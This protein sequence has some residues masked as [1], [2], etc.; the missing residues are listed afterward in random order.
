[1]SFSTIQV[2][3]RKVIQLSVRDESDRILSGKPEER[4]E[5]FDEAAG[6]VKFKRRKNDAMKKLDDRIRIWFVF[7]IFWANWNVRWFH[8]E[9]QCEKAK[10]YLSS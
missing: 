10:K 9:K 1:M 7:Q 6:I 2:L 3:V 4:R 5:L 8:S